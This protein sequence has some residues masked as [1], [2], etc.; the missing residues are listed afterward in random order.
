MSAPT[1]KARTVGLTQT[2]QPIG[3]PDD[4]VVYNGRPHSREYAMD[5]M[6]RARVP[7]AW[8]ERFMAE[9]PVLF[10]ADSMAETAAF[11]AFFERAKPCHDEK[12]RFAPCGSEAAEKGEK[13]KGERAE[14]RAKDKEA[15]DKVKAEKEKVKGEKAAY[16]DAQSKGLAAKAERSKALEKGLKTP[17]AK[18][19]LK[20]LKAISSEDT[21]PPEEGREVLPDAPPTAE[22]SRVGVPGNAVPPPPGV[23]RLKNAT[24]AERMVES[25]FANDFEANVGK[26]VEDFTN[27]LLKSGVDE[28]NKKHAGDPNNPVKPVKPDPNFRTCPTFETDAAK[29]MSIDYNPK[30]VSKAE[31]LM[32]KGLYNVATHQTANAICKKAF[33]KYLDDVVQHLPENDRRV[34]VTSGG[35]GSGKGFAVGAALGSEVM[36]NHAACWDAAGEQNGTENQWIMDECEKRGI[37]PTYVFV[38]AEPGTI[39]EDPKGGVVERAGEKGRMV[40]AQLFVDSYVDGA[41][42]FQAFMDKAKKDGK[43]A[44]F[45]IIDNTVKGTKPDG[46]TFWTHEIPAIPKKAFRQD[47][48]KLYDRCVKVLAAS[49]N[50]PA[51]EKGAITPSILRGGLIG[52]RC[53]KGK[54]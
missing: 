6:T 2:P 37:R 51:N 3:S 53:F 40:D 20:M 46:K 42:N 54:K 14:Q 18:R 49:A 25:R 8:V 34:L 45:K 26:Y 12:G 21:V 38:H 10:A 28:T 41:K 52:G 35:C 17:V 11:T 48:K 43:A 44:D 13:A 39:W 29:M 30:G 33:V 5:E 23:P 4:I 32:A 15:K 27:A 19:A 47:K 16:K 1:R 9:T 50:I 36:G 7:A 31:G 24:M 22:R